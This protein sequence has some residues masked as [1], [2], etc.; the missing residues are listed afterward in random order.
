MSSVT[1]NAYLFFPGHTREAMEFYQ[2]VFGGELSIQTNADMGMMDSEAKKDRIMHAHLKGGDI[3][4]MASDSDRESFG[5]SFIT[6]SLN[7]TDEA[8]LRELYD[9]L[10]VDGKNFYPIEMQA[11]GDLFGSVTDK[12]NVD[13]MMNIAAQK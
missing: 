6:L 3:D 8:K 7:G 2:T 9:K 1:L 12:Y 4:L 5:D 13:W 10:A 11:W